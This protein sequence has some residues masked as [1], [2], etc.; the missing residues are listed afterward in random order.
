MA[1]QQRDLKEDLDNVLDFCQDRG[2]YYQPG[3]ERIDP[4][5]L[6][7]LDI[8]SKY[9]IRRSFTDGDEITYY[10]M[11]RTVDEDDCDDN[12]EIFSV[13]LDLYDLETN[14]VDT[15]NNHLLKNDLLKKGLSEAS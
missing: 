7:L 2:F 6:A 13:S 11:E 12:K 1:Y 5:K 3:G 9:F 15:F 14:L 8:N 4:N 10:F